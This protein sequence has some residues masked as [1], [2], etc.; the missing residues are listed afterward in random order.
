LGLIWNLRD[1]RVGWVG[2]LGRIMHRGTEQNMDATNPQ[3][4]PP[5]G[6]MHH[7]KV[8]WVNTLT[9]DTLIVMVQSRSYVITMP[10]EERASVLAAVRE[11]LERRPELAGRSR[12]TCP[13]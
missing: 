8:E 7:L 5:F 4:G 12:S 13:T 10:A 6:L 3:V 1:E 11:F 9:P 2:E